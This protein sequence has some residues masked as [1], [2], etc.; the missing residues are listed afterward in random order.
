MK[1]SAVKDQGK[2]EKHFNQG[3]GKG[4]KKSLIRVQE[5]CE[6]VVAKIQEK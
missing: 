6:K 1:E 3:S 2:F 5:K 4:V